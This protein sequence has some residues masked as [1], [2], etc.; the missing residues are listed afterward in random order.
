M[1]FGGQN[2][3]KGEQAKL[4]QTLGSLW[5]T[6]AQLGLLWPGYSFPWEYLALYNPSAVAVGSQ[7]P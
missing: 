2:G 3:A 5:T 4:L 6:L 7:L 1:V